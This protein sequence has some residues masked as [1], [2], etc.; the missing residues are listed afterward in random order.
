LPI[1]FPKNQLISLSVDNRLCGRFFGE[2]P[3]DGE[4]KRA[5]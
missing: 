5:I 4:D 1:C 3:K 2:T